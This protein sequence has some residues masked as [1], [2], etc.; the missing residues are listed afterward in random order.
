M[1]YFWMGCGTDTTVSTPEISTPLAFFRCGFSTKSDS[2]SSETPS[3]WD[4]AADG[5]PQARMPI[6]VMAASVRSVGAD[7]KAG[8]GMPTI[9]PQVGPGLC[10]AETGLLVFGE[11]L[12]G[13]DDGYAAKWVQDEQIPVTG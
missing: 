2:C 6:A 11:I 12:R 9:V 7:F 3:A 1:Q 4:W 5:I 10:G 13:G 8:I